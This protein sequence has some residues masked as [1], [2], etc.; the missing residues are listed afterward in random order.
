MIGI[1]LYISIYYSSSCRVSTIKPMIQKPMITAAADNI[2]TLMVSTLI[3]AHL[4]LVLKV[5][6]EFFKHQYKREGN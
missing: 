6:N 4:T 1:K 2:I 3:Q 5:A